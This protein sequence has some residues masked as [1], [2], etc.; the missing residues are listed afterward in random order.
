MS[1]HNEIID[2]HLQRMKQHESMLV[3][4]AESV[5]KQNGL[6]ADGLVGEY[7]ARAGELQRA[8]FDLRGAVVLYHSRLLAQENLLW[9][10]MPAAGGGQ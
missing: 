3:E 5:E 1:N 10:A 4:L 6:F 2:R 8:V 9:A 7:L